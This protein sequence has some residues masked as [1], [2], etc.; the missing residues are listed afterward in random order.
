MQ[1]LSCSVSCTC[2]EKMGCALSNT[3]ERPCFQVD[4]VWREVMEAARAA[5]GCL[6]MAANAE[7]LHT[8]QSANRTLEEVQRG[9][10]AYLEI[11]RLAFP[12]R[13]AGGDQHMLQALRDQVLDVLTSMKVSP[14]TWRSGRLA[15]P[16][17]DAR[18]ASC[19]RSNAEAPHILCDR[20]LCCSHQCRAGNI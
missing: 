17:R 2:A 4:Q 12:R 14:P 1:S 7:L 15:F 9:L 6:A 5:P 3:G 19:A 13:A 8:L 10:S 20:P 16:R 11:K 18:C